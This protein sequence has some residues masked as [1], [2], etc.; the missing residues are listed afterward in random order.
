MA[1]VLK[2]S[3]Q[4]ENN[5]HNPWSISFCFPNKWCIICLCVCVCL[6]MW[7]CVCLWSPKKGLLG[8]AMGRGLGLLLCSYKKV[9]EP[10][11]LSTLIDA[12]SWECFP[13]GSTVGLRH[14]SPLS[15]KARLGCLDLSLVERS[16]GDVSIV[17]G[18]CSQW[19][20]GMVTSLLVSWKFH[21][22][23]FKR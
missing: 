14:P 21:P 8:L 19:G 20:I 13:Q 5:M 9:P 22:T 18:H 15:S 6:Y 11:L 16:E 10:L 1:I 12:R 4:R 3:A 7:V 23:T 17:L 2:I